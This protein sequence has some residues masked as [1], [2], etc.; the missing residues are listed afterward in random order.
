AIV[1]GDADNSNTGAAWI[2]TRSGGSWTQ[3]GSKLVGAGAAGAAYQGLSVALSADGSTAMTGGPLDS[4]GQGAVWVWTRSGGVWT[5][6][7]SKL[8]G[9]GGLGPFPEQGT[10]VSLAADG[11][12]GI[13]GAYLD[14][15]NDTG[16]AWIWKRAAGVW[17][18]GQK[19]IGG[20]AATPAA[21]QGF[22][23]SLSADATT[24][25]VGGVFDNS[26][27][28]A[29]WVF[30]VSA[31]LTIS[32]LI[33]GTPPFPAGGTLTYAINVVNNGPATATSVVVTDNLPAGTTF[34]SATPTQGSCSGT[35]TVTC[36]MGALTNGGTAAIALV[37]KS[38]STPEPVSNTASVV[39][40]EFDS[41]PANNSATSAISTI[42]P[43]TIPAMMDWLLVMLAGLLALV[44][45]L[46]IQR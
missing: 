5:Q 2:W 35:S 27:A 13:E 45:A 9:T 24:A 36:A 15:N 34:V 7:G 23:V 42:E 18:Q 25:I 32:K 20:G 44:G 46:R 22:S 40:A 8:V 39:G 4:N 19:L 17:T 10:S 1:G 29:A 38:S 43:A 3:V 37:L 28:G 6:Q 26:N 30:A 12:T 16:A 14:D 41:N 31:N 11:S 33:M 21:G